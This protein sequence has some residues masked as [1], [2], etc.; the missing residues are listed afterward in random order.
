MYTT[1]LTHPADSSRRQFLQAA[2]AFSAA[3]LAPKIPVSSAAAAED[4]ASQPP[5]FNALKPLGGR[6]HPITPDEF[7]PREKLHPP[8]EVAGWEQDQ[9]L[10]IITAAALN[11][12]NI[13]GGR[14]GIEETARYI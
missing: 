14:M 11:D 3:V 10:T 8:F 9:R 13:R 6:V 2:G 1:Q 12:Q 4:K 7:R 5:A